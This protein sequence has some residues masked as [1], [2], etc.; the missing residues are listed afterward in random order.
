MSTTA[1]V[2]A[3]SL[4]APTAFTGRPTFNTTHPQATFARRSVIRAQIGDSDS[5]FNK[6][7][8]NRKAKI[9]AEYRGPQG[10]TPYAEKV[11][12][13][14]AQLGFVIGLITEIFGKGHPTIVQ[15]IGIMGSPITH[16]F[17]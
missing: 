1:F 12:G 14:L 11:N 4:R 3:L 17:S 9:D 10:F 2:P 7:S 15:Q 8:A 13:R 16:F 5:R 6:T